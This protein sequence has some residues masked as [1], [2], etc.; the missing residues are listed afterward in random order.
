MINLYL[1]LNLNLPLAGWW[2]LIATLALSFLT[3]AVIEKPFSK[4]R[5]PLNGEKR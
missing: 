5:L 3:F 2:I 4:I 1:R